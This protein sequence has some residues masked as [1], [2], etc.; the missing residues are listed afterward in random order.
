[1][2]PQH[3]SSNALPLEL[4]EIQKYVYPEAAHI[5]KPNR[6]LRNN[7][8][9][10]DGWPAEYMMETLYGAT[11]GTQR[12]LV[13]RYVVSSSFDN[14]VRVWSLTTGKE[15]HVLRGHEGSVRSVKVAPDGMHVVSGSADSTVRVWSLATGT[16]VRKLQ[17]HEGDRGVTSVAVTPDGVHVVSGGFDSTVRV[18]LLETGARVKVLRGHEG[19]VTSVA[20]VTDGKH[21][22]SSSRDWTVRIWLLETG[23]RVKVL[24]GHQGPVWSVAVTP[25]GAHVVS[26]SDDRTV[27]VWSFDTGN[28]VRQKR[29]HKLLVASV[30]VTPDGEHVVSGLDDRTL[31]VWSL[32][33]GADVGELRLSERELRLSERRWEGDFV[34]SVAVTPDGVHVL[35]GVG[36]G[37]V[38]VFHLTTGAEVHIFRGYEPPW[39]F[40][41]SVTAT[42]EIVTRPFEYAVDRQL[43]T[44]SR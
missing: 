13:D 2:S 16:E 43:R 18:W 11:G 6:N 35:C 37:T 3:T 24:H 9:M 15:V 40:W 4:P 30:A 26:G 21:L 44:T 39:P 41:M 25:D 10:V 42:P 34:G 7:D 27:R 32:A 33:T 1:M 5:F 38:H 17:G 8:G 36:D 28:E 31:R 29:G 20:V 23:A 14:S 12:P 19:Y 22:V